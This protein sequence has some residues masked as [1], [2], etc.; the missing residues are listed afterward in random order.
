VSKDAT[1]LP[2]L[3]Q[4]FVNVT[5]VPRDRAFL[6]ALLSRTL[7]AST[8]NDDALTFERVAQLSP[9]SVAAPADDETLLDNVVAALLARFDF[10]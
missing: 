1:L 9:P 4:V 6:D 7:R 2:E 10:D 8:A 5:V 3:R